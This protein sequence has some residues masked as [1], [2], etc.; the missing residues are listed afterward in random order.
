MK[1]SQIMSHSQSSES[2]VIRKHTPWIASPLDSRAERLISH[3]G[4]SEHSKSNAEGRVVEFDGCRQHRH[5]SDIPIFKEHHESSVVELF[6][7]LF[8]VANLA[9]FTANHDIVDKTCR[10]IPH[11]ADRFTEYDSTHQLHRI[12]YY[13]LVYLA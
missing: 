12:L 3:H 9:T 4:E 1:L 10:Q 5:D 11:S 8:F 7:D 2:L 6:Y 13:P